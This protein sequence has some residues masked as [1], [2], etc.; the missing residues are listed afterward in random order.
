MSFLTAF[1]RVQSRGGV[2]GAE[3]HL[4]RNLHPALFGQCANP[5]CSS[6]WLHLFRRRIRPVFEGG[7]TC[8]KECTESCLQLAVHRE[9]SDRTFIR[10]ESPHRIPIGL[11]MLEKGWITRKDL[12]AALDLQRKSGDGRLGEWLVTLGSTDEATVTRAL[13][14]QWSCPV[15]SVDSHAAAAS[16]TGVMPR[17]FLDAF[18]VLPI[19]VWAGKLMYL[20]F[21]ESIDSVIAFGLE[22]MAAMR[23]ECGVVRTS[24]F[25]PSQALLLKET[26]PSLQMAE[27]ASGSAA[28]H[29]L[30]KTVERFQPAASRLVRVRDF[31]WLRM[32]L[33]S[34]PLHLVPIQ[35]IR[36]FVCTVGAF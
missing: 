32:I 10:K 16:L 12:S 36:D 13:G 29:L 21:E 33:S 19:R 4:R 34:Q 25:K 28:A 17:L 11:L 35:S 8:S 15:L 27:A 20:G 30:A 2:S 18:G 6:G 22:R 23:V 9:L 5:Q 31:L 7:W 26:F 1:P 24:Q 3:V 14:L